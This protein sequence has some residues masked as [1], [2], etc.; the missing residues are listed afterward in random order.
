MCPHDIVFSQSW[1]NCPGPRPNFDLDPDLGPNLDLDLGPRSNLDRIS[2]LGARV[3]LGGISGGVSAQ[4]RTNFGSLLISHARPA[5]SCA[6]PLLKFLLEPLS[7]A[8]YGAYS[9][10]SRDTGSSAP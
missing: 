4:S 9:R 2:D 10:G 7:Y 6:S 5:G 1:K 8:W 3:N